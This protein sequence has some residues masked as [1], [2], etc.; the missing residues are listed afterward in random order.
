MSDLPFFG[1]ERELKLLHDLN[2]ERGASLVVIKG[3]RR[4]G[5]TRLINEFCK[6]YKTISLIGLAPE[7]KITAAEQRQHF[8][9]QLEQQTSL[10]GLGADDWDH[11]FDNLATVAVA[12]Q[13]V[14]VFDEV[15]WM[16]SKDA[17]FLPKL[18]TAWDKHFSKNPQLILIL[19][20]SMSGWI[21]ENILG[22]TGFFGRTTLEIT[23]EELSLPQCVKFW[24][25]QAP[26]VSSYEMFKFLSVTGGVPRY[27]ELLRPKQSAEENIE[28]LCFQKGGIMVNEFD[29]IFSDLFS[30]RAPTYKQIVQALTHGFADQEEILSRLGYTSFSGVI[31]QYLEDLVETGYLARDFTWSIKSG[32][33]SKLSHYRLRDNYLRFYLRYIE[34]KKNAIERLGKVQ[35]PQWSTIMGLQFENLVLNHRKHLYDLLSINLEEIVYDNPFFLRPTK[36]REGVQIDLMI[37]TLFNTLYLCEI[38]FSKTEIGPGIIKEVQEKVERVQPKKGF[39]IRPIL[40]HVNGV[41]D[42]VVESGFFSKIIDFTQMLA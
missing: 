27:L 19:S 35:V 29:R 22:S 11:L 37:Q 32:Q 28:R 4:I 17:T 1:R 34:P 25:S 10:S 38:K 5:K 33:Q 14:L 36:E 24:G 26:H 7:K 12:G 8:A 9:N 39:S 2:E 15:N 42:A 23:L 16:G 13:I 40:I 20:G 6:E 21:E 3:R 30:K 18:K 41:S 31:S